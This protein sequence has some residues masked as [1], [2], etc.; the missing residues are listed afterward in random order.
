MDLGNP[1]AASAAE[2]AGYPAAGGS[3]YGKVDW[4][5]G[6]E[7]A[8]CPTVTGDPGKG[9]GGSAPWAAGPGGRVGAGL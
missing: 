2:A 3:G 4:E 9:A 7:E 6:W 1:G 5:L 8:T